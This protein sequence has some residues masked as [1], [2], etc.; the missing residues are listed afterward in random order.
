MSQLHP[1]VSN[2]TLESTIDKILKNTE[3]DILS[4]NKYRLDE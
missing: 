3:Q 2:S 1:L 4:N